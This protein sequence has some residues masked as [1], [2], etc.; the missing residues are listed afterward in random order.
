MVFRDVSS[1][2]SDKYR[3]NLRL[4]KVG[5]CLSCRK[6]RLFTVFQCLQK[7]SQDVGLRSAWT[8]TRNEVQ[9]ETS[10]S[11]LARH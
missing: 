4:N 5:G 8:S 11:L 6:S 2:E 7:W 1:Q 10:W 3:L 9:K